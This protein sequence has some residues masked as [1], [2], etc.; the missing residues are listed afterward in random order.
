MLSGWELLRGVMPRWLIWVLSF[1]LTERFH[2]SHCFFLV[3]SEAQKQNKN[4]AQRKKKKTTVCFLKICAWRENKACLFLCLSVFASS[5]THLSELCSVLAHFR[6]TQH[7]W[8]FLLCP[9]P[10]FLLPL[11]HVLILQTTSL[12][13]KQSASLAGPFSRA[14]KARTALFTSPW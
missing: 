12:V 14:R 4:Q 1:L 11:N 5:E 7:I 10:R 6:H 2:L 9:A 13:A 8:S 3:L